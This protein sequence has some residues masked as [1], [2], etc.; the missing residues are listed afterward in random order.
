VRVRRQGRERRPRDGPPQREAAA[1]A[2][3]RP[4]RRLPC[5][6]WRFPSSALPTVAP[7]LALLKAVPGTIRRSGPSGRRPLSSRS[8]RPAPHR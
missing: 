1:P 8:R 7:R 3:P 6:A 4:L 2:A 5:P